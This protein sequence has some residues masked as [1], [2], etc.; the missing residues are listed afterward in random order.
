MQKHLRLG[1]KIKNNS[2]I[3]GGFLREDKIMKSVSGNGNPASNIPPPIPKYIRKTTPLPPQPPPA[4]PPAEPPAAPPA[5]PPA[6]PHSSSRL[7]KSPITI[8]DT[9]ETTARIM[10]KDEME[11]LQEDIKN[12]LDKANKTNNKEN[13]VSYKEFINLFKVKTLWTNIETMLQETESLDD[14][15]YSDF[16]KRVMRVLKQ[17]VIEHY[18]E[19]NK[20]KTAIN[21]LIKTLDSVKDM[22]I[23]IEYPKPERLKHKKGM[24]DMNLT[25]RYN[26]RYSIKEL[27]IIL[28]TSLSF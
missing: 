18:K 17:G 28:K 10:T 5:E 1:Y 8:I 3:L 19:E 25:T 13:A 16:T 20:A 21:E 7:P 12:I 11:S 15:K 4:A 14:A 2:L 24:Y 23:K 26:K 22:L 6:D 27:L 9:G